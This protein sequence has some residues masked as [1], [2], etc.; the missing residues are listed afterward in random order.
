MMLVFL[1]LLSLLACASSQPLL[2]AI[3]SVSQYSSCTQSP[4]RPMTTINQAPPNNTNTTSDPN[5]GGCVLFGTDPVTVIRLQIRPNRVVGGQNLVFQIGD[6]PQQDTTVD[7]SLLSNDQGQNA[8]SGTGV[9]EQCNALLQKLVITFEST[10]LFARYSF[11]G[12]HNPVPYA[13][14]LS[15]NPT[16]TVCDP[17][18]CPSSEPICCSEAGVDIKYQGFAFYSSLVSCT[19]IETQN[20]FRALDPAFGPSEYGSVCPASLS[21]PQS[22]FY[23]APSGR[24]TNAA[25]DNVGQCTA[26]YCRVPS[27]VQSDQDRWTATIPQV[28]G[29]LCSWNELNSRPQPLMMASVFVADGSYSA[30]Q[31]T[32][33]D[34]LDL[35]TELGAQPIRSSLYPVVAQLNRINTGFGI[36]ANTLLGGVVQCGH[37]GPE[38]KLGP[39]DDMP[40]LVEPF[41]SATLLDA[42]RIQQRLYNPWRDVDRDQ[43]TRVSRNIRQKCVYPTTACRRL[44]LPSWFTQRSADEQ[45]AP[46]WW[47]YFPESRLSEYSDTQQCNK[48][49][50]LGT[51]ITVP[52]ILQALCVSQAQNGIGTQCVSQAGIPAG[53]P[54]GG[55]CTPEGAPANSGRLIDNVGVSGKCFPGYSQ[56]TVN[57]PQARTVFT[58][59]MVSLTYSKILTQLGASARPTGT[60]VPTANPKSV[61]RPSFVPVDYLQNQPNYWLSNNRLLTEALGGSSDQVSLDITLYVGASLTRSVIPISTGRFLRA[62]M[63]CDAT[64]GGAGSIAWSTQNAGN[65]PG[66]FW[67]AVNF[68]TLPTGGQPTQ[69]RYDL[70]PITVNTGGQL[71]TFVAK[72]AEWAPRTDNRT[73]GIVDDSTGFT[74]TGPLSNSLVATL[75]LYI[76]VTNAPN[77]TSGAGFLRVD[78]LQTGCTITR[79]VVPDT[80]LLE[81]RTGTDRVQDIS[82]QYICYYW[83]ENLYRCWGHYSR[84][85]MLIV[86]LL[87]SVTLFIGA[88]ALVITGILAYLRVRAQGKKLRSK[89]PAEMEKLEPE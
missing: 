71:V 44:F 28:F 20:G 6:L 89:V 85:W 48:N 33:V 14:V 9:G 43:Q 76:P 62:S 66:R 8:C 70:A 1:A 50:V 64:T 35:S 7:Y 38:N 54:T 86:N 74:Y 77:A 56:A 72:S 60:P 29:P 40:G 18:K 78:Q 87:M 80:S 30:S 39:L 41:S 73:H 42:R 63:L 69:I 46:G 13:V 22:D 26:G 83:Y 84:T 12:V 25:K 59:C 4:L 58:P 11:A 79:G 34:R 16:T 49:G 67:V 19:A 3:Q 68:T 51:A 47:Y 17:S 32:N 65:L 57:D 55:T 52:S 36:V 45:A 10:R 81:N 88:V 15:E 23:D 75:T 37:G 53:T 31:P 5:N 21:S 82:N 24:I 27:A 2:G 61:Q